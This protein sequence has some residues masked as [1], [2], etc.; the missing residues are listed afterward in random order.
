MQ[1]RKCPRASRC[2]RTRLAGPRR[3]WAGRPAHTRLARSEPAAHAGRGGL[4]G[5]RSAEPARALAIRL[6]QTDRNELAVEAASPEV[7]GRIHAETP[8]GHRDACPEGRHHAGRLR[9]QGPADV[10]GQ[11]IHEPRIGGNRIQ[12][13]DRRQAHGV[14]DPPGTARAPAPA[15][16]RADTARTPSTVYGA[17]APSC[18]VTL[19]ESAPADREPGG[20]VENDGGLESDGRQ[21]P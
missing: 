21:P 4:R 12:S 5:S 19:L 13:R 10:K 20:R 8:T 9:R 1:C 17:R 16:R 2:R 18:L 7:A 11:S 15:R 14:S 3:L 6:G